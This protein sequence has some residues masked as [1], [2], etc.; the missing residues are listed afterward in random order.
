MPCL[1][2]GR[3]AKPGARRSAQSGH[4]RLFSIAIR[5]RY[6]TIDSPEELPNRHS[7]SDA[8]RSVRCILECE[9]VRDAQEFVERGGDVVGA[10]RQIL[11]ERCMAIRR[12]DNLPAANATSGP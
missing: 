5:Y 1:T 3:T 7:F 8:V 10:G 12:T 9:I 2:A 11:D 4:A 6:P